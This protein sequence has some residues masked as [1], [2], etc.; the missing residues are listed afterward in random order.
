MIFDHITNIDT[1]KGLNERIMKGLKVLSETDFS[2]MEVGKYEI[3]GTNIFML[4]QEHYTKT[5]NYK[6]EAHKD[7]VDIQ[8]L[9]D[10]NDQMGYTRL[11]DDLKEIEALPEKD[12]WIYDAPVD[13][14]K[15]TSGQFMILWPQDV[16][17]PN[18]AV[19]NKSSFCKKVVVKVKLG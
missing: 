6:L 16:H 14:I 11:T 9:Y 18:I 19:D 17:M 10:G 7:Y 3:D 2:K 13:F 8:Y 4:V 1:Y 15:M 12:M 5:E